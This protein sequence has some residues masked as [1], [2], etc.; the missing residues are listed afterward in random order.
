MF[1]PLIEKAS[2]YAN[3][4]AIQSNEISYSYQDI[5]DR[6]MTIAQI[7]LDQSI[8][9]Q[10]PICFLLAPSFDYVSTQWGIW[11]TNGIVTPL[12]TAHPITELKYVIDHSECELIISSEE[13]RSTIEQLKIDFPQ[14]H[15][16]YI[17]SIPNIETSPSTNRSTN[18]PP[19]NRDDYAMMLYTSGTTNRPKGVITTHNNLN[20]QME[21]LIK[22]WEWNKNDH[23]LHFLPLHHLHGILNKLC[24]A[25]Y[26]GAKITFIPKFNAETVFN[27]LTNNS[28]TLFM[29]VPTVYKKMLDAYQLLNEEEKTEIS[30]T[31]KKLRLMVSGS[32]ALPVKLLKEWEKISGHYLLERYGMTEIGMGI[33]NPYHTERRAGTIGFPL[34]NVA[35]RLNHEG[36]IEVKGPTVFDHYW[37]NKAATNESFTEDH[38]FKT[39]D[40]AELDNGYYKILGR[41]SV[42][43]IKTGGYKVSAL[44][45]EETLRTHPLIDDCAVVGLEDEEW[46]EIIAASIIIKNQISITELKTW[47]KGNLAPYK[48]PQH[49]LII[50]ELP[51]NVMG[52]VTKKQV[53]QLFYD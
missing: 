40:I 20:A 22:A 21:S 38:W 3:R 5:L 26:V 49:Y 19:I 27:K 45:I 12:C 8:K 23:I 4:I 44:E 48:V 7:I 37:K 36:E 25:L 47:L 2:L 41:N 17:E 32:A 6:S 11:R 52:K 31:L 53:K 29:A 43:I 33:S 42:D 10:N 9:I 35:I 24:C 15:F 51:R 50:K 30:N 18:F 46:G 13:F 1:A 34:P 14:K 28:F 16:I 39:G